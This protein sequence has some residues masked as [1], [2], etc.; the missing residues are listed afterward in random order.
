MAFFFFQDIF[1]QIGTY[2]RKRHIFYPEKY[3]Q[4]QPQSYFPVTEAVIF[5]ILSKLAVIFSEYFKAFRAA[6]NK[7]LPTA[8]SVKLILP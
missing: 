3:F 8:A 6:I 1:L 2:S 5:C 4:Q 7:I